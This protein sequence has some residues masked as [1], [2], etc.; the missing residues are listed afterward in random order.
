MSSGILGT[1]A[2]LVADINLLVQTAL[3]F[4]L[5]IAALQARNRRYDSHRTLMT[6]AVVINAAAI[7]AVMNPSFFRVLPFAV[8]NPDA[9]GPTVMWPHVALGAVA[10]LMGAFLVIRLGLEPASAPRLRRVMAVTL[11]LWLA[12]LVVG[13]ALYYMW[14]V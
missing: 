8:R 10:E 3:F 1:R 9:P 6:V 13:F 7:V 4:I 2:T 11:L 12:A 5:V 14:Y